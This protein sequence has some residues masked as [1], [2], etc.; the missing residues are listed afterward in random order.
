M[1]IRILTLSGASGS[2]KTT[3]ARELLKNKEFS[4]SAF[5]LIESFTTRQPRT[6]DL[7]GEYVYVNQESFEKIKSGSAFIWTTSVRESSYGTLRNS[8]DLALCSDYRISL[9]LLVPET[10][11]ILYDYF[12]KKHNLLRSLFV[13]TAPE[14]ISRR[15]AS[16]DPKVVA[17]R[18]NDQRD[19]KA[20]MMETGVRFETISNNGELGETIKMVL[21]GLNES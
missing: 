1:S 15:M 16:E 4:T 20:Q 12:P 14:I 9:M 2:G 21:G 18:L 17:K 3:I 11:K 19:W 10:V 7:I 13:E 5:R 8:I 6:S